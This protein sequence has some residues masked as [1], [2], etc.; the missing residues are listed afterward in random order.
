MEPLRNPLRDPCGTHAEPTRN[1]RAD[2]GCGPLWRVHQAGGAAWQRIYPTTDL[3]DF[4]IDRPPC[5]PTNDRP[6]FPFVFWGAGGLSPKARRWR[7][8]IGK[9]FFFFFFQI[10]DLV[11]CAISEPR[12]TPRKGTFSSAEISETKP[13]PRFRPCNPPPRREP[14]PPPGMCGEWPDGTDAGNRKARAPQ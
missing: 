8:F 1:P 10:P 11:P 3:P 9:F 5:A 2:R 4:L 13:S 12:W 6:G 14:T 7:V